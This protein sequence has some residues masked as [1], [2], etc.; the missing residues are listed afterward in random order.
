MDGLYILE[1]EVEGK[2]KGLSAGTSCYVV[3]VGHPSI[4]W[5]FLPQSL[6]TR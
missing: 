2:E 4:A 5:E 3:L 6:V 1:R